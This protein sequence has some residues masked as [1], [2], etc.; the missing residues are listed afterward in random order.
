MG[1]G[2]GGGGGRGGR[3]FLPVL[4]EPLKG[5]DRCGQTDIENVANINPILVSPEDILCIPLGG[6]K[7]VLYSYKQAEI[8]ILL[9]FTVLIQNQICTRKHC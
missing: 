3:K 4:P 7:K 2:G 1:G 9:L 5:H 8:S 6:K